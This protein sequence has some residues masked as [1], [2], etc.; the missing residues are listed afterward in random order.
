MLWAIDTHINTNILYMA[1]LYRFVFFFICD[2]HVHLTICLCTTNFV[3]RTPMHCNRKTVPN[4]VISQSNHRIQR[5]YYSH[6]IQKWIQVQG[7]SHV[8]FITWLPNLKIANIYNFLVRST[9]ISYEWQLNYDFK[10]TWI[11]PIKPHCFNAIW[12]NST[13]YG[14]V[15]YSS[16]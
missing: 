14:L 1:I 8:H 13:L 6:W 2:M 16:R 3:E 15:W 4:A 10:F 9:C 5:H 7:E 12:W 11:L